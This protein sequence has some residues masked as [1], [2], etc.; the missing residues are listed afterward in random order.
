[1]KRI[2]EVPKPAPVLDV[3]PIEATTD[4]CKSLGSK[5]LVDKPEAAVYVPSMRAR[6]EDRH[7]ESN[8]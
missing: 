4:D 8:A 7:G 5:R 2:L 1:M 3:A 6:S